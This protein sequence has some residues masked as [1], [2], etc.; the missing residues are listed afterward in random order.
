METTKT[1][2]T[3]VGTLPPQAQT[4]EKTALALLARF[5]PV[6][7]IATFLLLI[8]TLDEPQVLASVEADTES[9]TVH[10]TN[11]DQM[12]IVLPRAMLLTDEGERCAEDV[13]LRTEQGA[14]VFY[15]VSGPVDC[16]L[17]HGVRRRA[18]LP[19]WTSN[20]I[21]RASLQKLER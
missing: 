8:V 17:A 14:D 18:K 12:R 20:A 21:L 16:Q 4:P 13:T 5:L 11:Q 7:A 3:V 15:T 19:A 9:A 10:I 2:E 1:S 6:I